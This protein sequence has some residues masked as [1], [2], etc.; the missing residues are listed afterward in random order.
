MGLHAAVDVERVWAHHADAHQP[1]PLSLAC[2][3]SE[4]S[5]SHCGCSMC[6]SSG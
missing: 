4:R 6:Q 2:R 5:A 3:S 1:S